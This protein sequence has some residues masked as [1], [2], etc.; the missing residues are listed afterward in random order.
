[1]G[2]ELTQLKSLVAIVE[3]GSVSGAAR[4]QGV[5]QPA[6]TQQLRLLEQDL[7]LPLFERTGR[8]LVLTAA[9]SAYVVYARQALAT[10]DEGRAAVADEARAAQ[11]PLVLAVPVTLAIYHLPRWLA[12][13]RRRQPD[14]EVI[15]HTAQSRVVADLLSARRAD[16][17]LATSPVR[18]PRRH[19]ETLFDEPI[20]LVGPPDGRRHALA[21]AELPLIM[22][23]AGGG[24]RADL[25]RA[26]RAA[27]ISPQ[28]KME[29][30]SVEAIK[31]FVAGGL[32][33]ALLPESA[34]RAELGTRTL[35]RVVT[36]DLPE[37]RRTT[38]VLWHRARYRSRASRAF[39]A[40]IGVR[41]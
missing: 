32:G 39:L 31:A 11:N 5:S 18:D 37:I 33:Y 25:D 41:I 40:V 4:R 38:R 16:L 29:S 35:R 7:G 13:F 26:F 9:G 8:G 27:G 28:V 36:T 24:F 30:D 2:M 1:M 34:V 21:L 20:V 23:A 14:V 19:V 17:G 22:F 6:V 10:L 12:R 15:V 3:A